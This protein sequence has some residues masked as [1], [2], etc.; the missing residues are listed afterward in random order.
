MESVSASYSMDELA[1]ETPSITLSRDIFLMISLRQPGKVVIRQDNGDGK[2]LR[3]P[4]KRHKDTSDF[5]FRIRV[6]PEQI[7]LKI[8]TSVEPKEIKYGY[9]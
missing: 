8:F 2:W 7:K 9:I 5:E 4:I 1:W 3:V 6:I